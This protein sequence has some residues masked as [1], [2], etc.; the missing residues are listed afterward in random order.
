MEYKGYDINFGLT[1]KVAIITGGLSGIG[2]AIAALFAQKGA[3]IVIFD[4][5]DE[6][7]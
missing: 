1:D 3:K 2:E 5:K 4:I 6:T 7:E